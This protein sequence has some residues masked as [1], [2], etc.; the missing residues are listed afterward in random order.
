MVVAR[1]E[2]RCRLDGVDADDGAAEPLLIGTDLGGEVRQRRLATVF[3]A[4]L[5]A[6]RFDLAPLAANAARPRILAERIDHGA[7][8]APLR[9][10]LE[11][12][13]ATLVETLGRIDQTE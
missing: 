13:A 5:F 3:A 8:H 11:L 7:T 1:G 4:K 10:C 6:R 9:E 2:R 12:D